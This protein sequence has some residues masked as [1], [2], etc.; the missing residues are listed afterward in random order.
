MR[1]IALTQGK[2][3]LVDDDDWEALSAFKWYAIRHPHTFYAVR[4]VPNPDGGG[5]RQKRESMHRLVLVWKLGRDIVPGLLCDHD[6]GNGLN[7][8]RF[9]LFEKTGRGNREN[10][11]VA[12]TSRYLGVSWDKE[13]GKW[14][15]RIQAGKYL[16]LGYYDTEHE[17][18]LTRERYIEAHPELG[19][20]SN[21]LGGSS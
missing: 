15:A 10:L 13:I 3:A 6:D 11:H 19:A 21:F 8:Q 20:K 9:N 16:N 4:H 1:E 5:P 12:K 14:V 18:A 2:V 17:A 7:N